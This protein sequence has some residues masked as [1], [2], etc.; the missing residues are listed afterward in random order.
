MSV[1]KKYCDLPQS[2]DDLSRE[3]VDCAFKVHRHLGPG[4]TE[5]IYEDCFQIEME[6]RKIGFQ[7]QYPVQIIYNGR[8]IPSEF[9]LDLVVENKILIE[10]KSVDKLTPVFDAQIYSYL[11]ATKL[12][13]G[14][15]MN[16]NVSLIKDGIKR[17]VPRN[18]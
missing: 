14:F 8:K 12:P 1:L 11:K 7:R 2:L 10:L 18:I 5:K 9:R 15:L 6:D 4:Y 16:F 13:L 17:F 3:V